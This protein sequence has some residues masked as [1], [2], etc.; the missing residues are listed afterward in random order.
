MENTNKQQ[1]EQL[2]KERINEMDRK[3]TVRHEDG[4]TITL[5]HY[6][7]QK[8]ISVMC[9]ECMGFVENVLECTDKKC[10]LYPYRRRT[11]LNRSRAFETEEEEENEV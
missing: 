6:T 7:K 10:P 8:A 9:S 4:G 2:K 5:D 3:H 11:I 1:T